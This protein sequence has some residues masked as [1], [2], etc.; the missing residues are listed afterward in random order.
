MKKVRNCFFIKNKLVYFKGDVVPSKSNYMIL[1]GSMLLIGLSLVSTV[2]TIIQ[3]QINALA[4]VRLL[5]NYIYLKNMKG[6]IDKDYQAALE[7][8]GNN[9]AGDGSVI[10]YND[11]NEHINMEQSGGAG[12]KG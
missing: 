10:D 12:K 5:I 2:L 4:D 1:V 7:Q 3:K 8:V 11:G 9:P 6:T